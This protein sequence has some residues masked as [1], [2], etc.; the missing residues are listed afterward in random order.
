MSGCA[1]LT[2]PLPLGLSLT[3]EDGPLSEEEKK[4]MMKI[5]YYEALGS[6]MWLQVATRPDLA[7]VIGLLA[8]FAHNPGKEHWRALKH[9]MGYMKGTINYGITYQAGGDLKLIGYV[10]SNFAGCRSTKMVNRWEHLPSSKRACILGEQA[11]RH[12]CIIHH[13]SR[14]HGFF[15]SYN[16]SSIAIKILQ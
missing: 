15:I 12:C 10:D 1:P 16:S 3:I 9:V 7:F 4:E 14:V 13:R 8:R 11:T 6:L 2:T 5:P